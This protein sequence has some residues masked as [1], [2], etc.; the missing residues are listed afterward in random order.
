MLSTGWQHEDSLTYDT[1]YLKPNLVRYNQRENRRSSHKQGKMVLG[2]VD[3]G[4][5]GVWVVGEG[6]TVKDKEDCSKE[7]DI[8]P[9]NV[10]RPIHETHKRPTDRR[11]QVMW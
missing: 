10:T 11:R 8:K 3:N 5:G 7:R 9:A 1:W 2:M 6:N 4:Q